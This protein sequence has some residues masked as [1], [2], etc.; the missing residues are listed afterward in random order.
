MDDDSDCFL[1]YWKCLDYCMLYS[2]NLIDHKTNHRHS[3][4]VTI[5]VYGLYRTEQEG[6]WN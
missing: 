4:A 6:D 1:L 5:L 2:Y 3:V